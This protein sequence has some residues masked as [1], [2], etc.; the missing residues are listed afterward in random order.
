M[1]N[2]CYGIFVCDMIFSLRQ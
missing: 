1:I 2:L